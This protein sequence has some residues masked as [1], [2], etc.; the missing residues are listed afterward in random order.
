MVIIEASLGRYTSELPPETPLIALIQGIDRSFF[1]CIGVIKSLISQP[2]QMISID[3]NRDI[4]NYFYKEF[5]NS[6]KTY[7]SNLIIYSG[8]TT[9]FELF[10]N[11]PCKLTN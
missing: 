3:G 1:E 5:E 11:K 7:R 8:S 2:A 4:F 9:R 6:K 10:L